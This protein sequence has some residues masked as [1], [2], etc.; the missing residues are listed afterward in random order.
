MAKGFNEPVSGF[1]A[2]KDMVTVP[3]E[4][5]KV[6]SGEPFNRVL[7]VNTSVTVRILAENVSVNSPDIISKPAIS[8]IKKEWGPPTL[9]MMSTVLYAKP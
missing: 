9:T 6:T 2:A 8:L 3:G 7:L 1:V 4:L 5:L